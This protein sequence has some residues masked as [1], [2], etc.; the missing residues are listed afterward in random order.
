[1][2]LLAAFASGLLFGAGLIVSGMSNPAK[3]LNFLDFA[4]TWTGTWDPSLA[5][6]MAGALVVTAIGYR[7]AL[8]RGAPVCEPEF[9]LPPRTVIDRPLLAGAV[10]FGMGWGLGGFCPGPAFVALT[11][12]GASTIAFV[13]CMLIG[14]W[15]ARPIWPRASENP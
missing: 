8:A 6:V 13:A 14:M 3:V 11:Q 2:K 7:L 1:M 10:L 15:F 12:D 4:G 9:Q 5:L